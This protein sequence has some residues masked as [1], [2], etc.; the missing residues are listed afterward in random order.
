MRPLAT[1]TLSFRRSMASAELGELVHAARAIRRDDRSADHDP[2]LGVVALIEHLPADAKTGDVA[3]GSR[4]GQFLVGPE[5]TLG[6]RV[7]SR[8]PA[9]LGGCAVGR[10]HSLG[11][12]PGT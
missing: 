3:F 4:E 7:R 9:A 12:R 11:C 5:Q 1:S 6:P 10:K 8:A 2:P